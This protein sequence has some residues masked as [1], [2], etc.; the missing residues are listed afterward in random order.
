MQLSHALQGTVI[1]ANAEMILLQT[2]DYGV[3]QVNLDGFTPDI[4]ILLAPGLVITVCYNGQMTRS[5]P[6]QVSMTNLCIPT[7]FGTIENMQ[8]DRFTLIQDDNGMAVTVRMLAS[9]YLGEGV[10]L[11]N[12]AHVRVITNGVAALSEPPQV[13]A[14]QIWPA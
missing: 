2:Q 10:I 5:I 4:P 12:N 3:V 13:T 8:E 6:P 7:L 14:L 11:A 9:I 1:A